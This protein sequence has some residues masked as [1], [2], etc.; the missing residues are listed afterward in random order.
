MIENEIVQ[1]AVDF[2]EYLEEYNY[3]EL[4]NIDCDEAKPYENFEELY[5]YV[6][7][8][9]AFFNNSDVSDFSECLKNSI[10]HYYLN[11]T[12]RP[13]K[14]FEKERNLE[15]KIQEFFQ[16]IGYTAYHIDFDAGIVNFEIG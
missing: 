10:Y 12:V 11:H 5:R 9:D 13:L 16:E 1:R 14:R 2:F 7:T 15:G 8:E 3:P 6:L 4:L